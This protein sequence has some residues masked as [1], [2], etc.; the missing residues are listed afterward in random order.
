MAIEH[1]LICYSYP[2]YTCGHITMYIECNTLYYYIYVGKYTVVRLF[3]YAKKL[4]SRKLL[5][6]SEV[7]FY[8]YA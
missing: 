8:M 5:T 2:E 4:G 3:D 6:Y 1:A 7:V